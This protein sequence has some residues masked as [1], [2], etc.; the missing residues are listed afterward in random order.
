MAHALLWIPKTT[1]QPLGDTPA[2]CLTQDLALEIPADILLL[3][4]GDPRDIFFTLFADV[5]SSGKE[6]IGF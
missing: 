3:G 2:V 5:A 4:C 6:S 1:F